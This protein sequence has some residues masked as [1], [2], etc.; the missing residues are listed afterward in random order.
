MKV[1]DPEAPMQA[2]TGSAPVLVAVGIEKAFDRTR[3]LAGAELEVYSGEVMGLLGANGAG[4]STLS[5]VVSGHVIRDA[6]SITFQGRSLSLRNAREA[7]QHG[8][9]IHYIFWF[10][11]IIFLSDSR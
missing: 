8:I 10:I 11:D 4:K 1:E 9:T 6:G 3:A 5:K 2:R 7:I